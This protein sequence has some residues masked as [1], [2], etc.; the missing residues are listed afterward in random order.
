MW[1]AGTG[2]SYGN[3]MKVQSD[4]NLMVHTF[5]GD[6]LWSTGSHVNNGDV[7]LQLDSDG[8]VELVSGNSNNVIWSMGKNW[9]MGKYSDV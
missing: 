2:G 7:R 1:S 4:G 8:N 5:K 9:S 3:Y 6:P